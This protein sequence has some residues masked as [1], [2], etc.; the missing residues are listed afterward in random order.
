MQIVV[1][2]A[3]PIE[4]QQIQNHLPANN[5]ETSI[6]F[7]SHRSGIGTPA[8]LFSLTHDFLKNKPDLAIQV[9]IS[10][11][12]TN[13]EQLGETYII[14]NDLFADTGVE[15]PDT[16]HDL[17]D[18]GLL[19]ENT[20]PYHGKKLHN[21]WLPTYN[22]LQLPEVDAITVNEITTSQKRIALYREKYQPAMESM[23]GAA[24][25]Y[26]CLMLKIP[27]IQMR[28]SSNLVGE[29]DKQKWQLQKALDNLGK[30]LENYLALLPGIS[31]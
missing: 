8:T 22:L 29:R 6:S 16:W 13:V 4:W 9:G 30:N 14:S 31:K 2:A 23:E 17:F 25:H 12:F 26:V 15:E 11:S 3:S 28:T 18:L 24:F 5:G 1:T 7:T 19:R 10:G 20:I 27:F 21:P